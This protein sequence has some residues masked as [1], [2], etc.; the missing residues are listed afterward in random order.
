MLTPLT[1][2]TQPKNATMP[3]Q[4][5]HIIWIYV[6]V[7]GWL[8]DWMVTTVRAPYMIFVQNFTLPDFYDKTF[9]QKCAIWDNFHLWLNSVNALNKYQWTSELSVKYQ[10]KTHKNVCEREN[11]LFYRESTPLAKILQSCRQWREGQ[12]SPVRAPA[13]LTTKYCLCV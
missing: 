2:L 5:I 3:I 11:I 13:V 7:T 12:I 1:M 8:D 9:T 6:Q 10:V 4:C